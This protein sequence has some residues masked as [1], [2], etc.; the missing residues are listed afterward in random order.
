MNLRDILNS[1]KI[2]KT[3]ATEPKPALAEKP[4]GEG[5]LLS[6]E[7]ARVEKIDALPLERMR[8]YMTQE[9]SHLPLL[10]R[11]MLLYDL[12]LE[13]R[14]EPCLCPE[15]PYTG[16]RLVDAP[17]NPHLEAYR[18][19]TELDPDTAS[20][21]FY[22]AGDYPAREYVSHIYAFLPSE[23]SDWDRALIARYGQD[24]R[25]SWRLFLAHRER[26]K[27]VRQEGQAAQEAAFA[28]YA[29]HFEGLPE[30]Q[31][32]A[33]LYAFARQFPAQ[34]YSRLHSLCTL[35]FRMP[36]ERYDYAQ[37]RPVPGVA[38]SIN[39]DCF[40]GRAPLLFY[41]LNNYEDI[42]RGM[43]LEKAGSLPPDP[44]MTEVYSTIEGYSS[45]IRLEGLRGRLFLFRLEKNNIR[46]PDI[47]PNH[48][49]PENQPDYI[50]TWPGAGEF[51][52]VLGEVVDGKLYS[53]HRDDFVMK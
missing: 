16:Q 8:A 7:T 38:F 3:P 20:R 15:I 53:L 40:A 12:P 50:F 31:R 51:S 41:C 42:P 28:E 44:W 22:Y 10:T 5:D 2:K 17:E 27:A 37:T 32:P 46:K 39:P 29:R 13:V 48:P 45:G 34:T 49:D 52:C 26:I 23:P 11:A 19:P 18:K 9:F 4:A 1:L 14:P 35:S 47:F 33:A 43:P 30:T 25:E 21:I 24:L 6:D 36:F